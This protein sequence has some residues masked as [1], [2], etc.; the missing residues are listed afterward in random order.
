MVT[1]AL[2]NWLQALGQRSVPAERAAVIYAMDPVYAAGFAFLL[3]GETLGTAGIA[4]ASIITGAA[5]WNQGQQASQTE[6][7]QAADRQSL[8]EEEVEEW[9]NRNDH[10]N[11]SCGGEDDLAR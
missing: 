1:T 3:L 2:T 11:V 5:L 6:G 4:G 9:G 10:D 8:P 7:S